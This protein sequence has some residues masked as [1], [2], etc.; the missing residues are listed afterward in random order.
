MQDKRYCLLIVE[1]SIDYTQRYF[2]TDKSKLTIVMMVWFKYLKA[3][4][5]VNVRD[6]YC[7]NADENRALE[8]VCKKEE[9]IGVKFEYIMPSTTQQNSCMFNQICMEAF[10]LLR[11][12]LWAETAITVK[13]LENNEISSEWSFSP[14]QQFLRRKRE[15]HYLHSKI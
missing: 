8:S 3:T 9:E 4:Q 12:G 5:A 13:L 15:A 2:L 1:D 11:N 7:S 10:C 6:I 14:F